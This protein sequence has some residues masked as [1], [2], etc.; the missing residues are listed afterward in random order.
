MAD[1]NSP[2][3]LTE[4]DGKAV[5]SVS[6]KR[7]VDADKVSYQLIFRQG[8]KQV[9]RLSDL[10]ADQVVAALGEEN[11]KAVHWSSEQ[12]GL[13]K[14]KTL[15]YA[16]GV[17][18]TL[19]E[20][21]SEATAQDRVADAISKTYDASPGPSAASEET[22]VLIDVPS[23]DQRDDSQ[24]ERAREIR[25]RREANDTR[26]D[27][28]EVE[29]EAKPQPAPALKAKEDTTGLSG[30]GSGMAQS[31]SDNFYQGWFDLL[32]RKESASSVFRNERRYRETRASFDAG[33]ITSAA[34]LRTF[35]SNGKSEPSNEAA[36]NQPIQLPRHVVGKPESWTNQNAQVS[37]DMADRRRLTA[38]IEG[39]FA[40][41]AT[42]RQVEAILGDKLDFLPK[43]DRNGFVVQV[44]ATLGIPSQATAE[45]KVEFEDWKQ[46]RQQRLEAQQQYTDVGDAEAG[47]GDNGL[48]EDR[49]I[50]HA[51]E[52]EDVE[53][54]RAREAAR[55]AAQAEVEKSFYH[56]EN[57]YYHRD[58]KNRVAFVEGESKLRTAES[59]A[60]IAKSMVK[61]AEAKGWDSI[62]VAGTDEFRR[63]VWM[64]AALRGLQVRG[65]KPRDVD[66]AELAEKQDARL[67]NSVEQ[68]DSREDGKAG[69]VQAGKQPVK[70][71]EQQ[72][73][74]ESRQPKEEPGLVGK[75]LSHGPA[76]FD[77]KRDE[78][79]SYYVRL[80][81]A[82]GEKI[83]WG[84]DLPRALEE[85]K[86]NDGDRIRLENLG[87][88][89][90]QVT[91]N[92]RDESGRVIGQETITSHRNQWKA[93]HVP[94]REQNRSVVAVT[95][96]RINPEAS[97]PM[98]TGAVLQSVPQEAE[99]LH[100]KSK[101]D[102]QRD[103]AAADIFKRN[104]DPK[105]WTTAAEKYP[106]LKNAYAH[107]AIFK[108]FADERLPE[109]RR[110]PFLQRQVQNIAS[111]VEAGRHI[112]AVK[113]ATSQ[114][115]AK[116]KSLDHGQER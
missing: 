19:V 67:R 62:K 60:Y 50:D 99:D 80:D 96:Q 76:K 78:K 102:P 2:T 68:G 13:L 57:K 25:A 74:S 88:Q 33:E 11:G 59:D 10:S 34:E 95:E 113:I 63:A 66:L 93:T 90:V 12:K 56:V 46:A 52:S 61:V 85:G 31:I 65:Y 16:Q 40:G 23:I 38:E 32:Q 45:G 29:R 39:Q 105:T 28:G 8:N 101:L 72:A 79:P 97:A 24:N 64:E 89:A 75:V 104:I 108:K 54:A 73:Q 81:T 91:A 70:T 84:V 41:G 92:V 3:G 112:G 98:S 86:V 18:P 14:G 36:S 109:S 26:L 55:L 44:R 87:R 83:V 9:A 114:A 82:A 30:L 106:Q 115:P 51:A 100:K 21:V 77:F 94:D 43:E 53:A 116:A 22:G 103:K 35:L 49:T 110:G 17:S 37:R 69:H 71:G 48:D 58:N 15:H 7:E 27:D 4:I 5:S 47:H 1:E 42:A 20:S 111:D 107:L 6:Y